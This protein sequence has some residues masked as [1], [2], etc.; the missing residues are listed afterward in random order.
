M[1]PRLLLGLAG[2][3][4]VATAIARISAQTSTRAGGTIRPCA[5]ASCKD[6]TAMVT[7]LDTVLRASSECAGHK[8]LIVTD[9]YWDPFAF[10]EGSGPEEQPSSPAIGNWGDRG[11]LALHVYSPDVSLI[12]LRRK[13][14]VRKAGCLMVFS[15]PTWLGPDR[16]RVIV[17]ALGS[18]P[19]DRVE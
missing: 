19:Q 6:V 2:S 18:T 14:L 15:A 1:I 11:R 3:M 4:L 5:A 10:D 13:A 17:A 16:A 9:L 8:V 7:A 12:D